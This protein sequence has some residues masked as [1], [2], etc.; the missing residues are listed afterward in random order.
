MFGESFL[1]NSHSIL[2]ILRTIT[3][4]KF[5]IVAP[6]SLLLSMAQIHSSWKIKS[7]APDGFI[8]AE[9]DEQTENSKPRHLIKKPHDDDDDDVCVLVNA[10]KMSLLQ[11]HFP[12]PQG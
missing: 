9:L 12:R 1:R 4:D 5:P 3:S 6:G 7:R 2:K 8:A 10:L 11:L